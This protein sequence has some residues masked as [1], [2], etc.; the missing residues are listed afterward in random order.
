MYNTSTLIA[1][2]VMQALAVISPGPDFAI[3]VRNSLL[4]SRKAGVFTA[5]GI[6]S[7]VWIHV[8]YCSLGLG[9]LIGELP[10]LL[11]GIKVL[12]CSYLI[13]IGV[14]GLRATPTPLASEGESSKNEQY[15]SRAAFQA[16]FLTNVLNPKA[17]LYFISVFT[18]VVDRETPFSTLLV[19]GAF[20][21]A[22]TLLWFLG[23]AYGLSTPSVRE[24]FSRGAH[25]VDRVTGGV[26]IC[27]GLRLAL[28]TLT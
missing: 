16:G 11:A 9:Y 13:Y 14:K 15:S 20:I 23:V 19:Y 1:L 4:Y 12:G 10:W 26:L 28:T 5:L 2:I 24:K 18:V 3:V 6:A 7:A 25:W 8:A 22:I 27:L 21:V 17:I